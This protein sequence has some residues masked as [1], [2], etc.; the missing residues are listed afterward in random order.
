QEAAFSAV[1]LRPGGGGR[2]RS[3][4][5]HPCKEGCQGCSV[6][7]EQCPTCREDFRRSG[8][9]VPQKGPGQ[10]RDGIRALTWSPA[11]YLD[12]LDRIQARVQRMVHLRNQ[13]QQQRFK[14]LQQR[15]NVVGLCVMYKV[16][17]QQTPHLAPLRL[18]PPPIATHDTRHSHH[19]PKCPTP[20]SSCARLRVTSAP[21]SHGKAAC[22]TGW[23]SPHAYTTTHA[24]R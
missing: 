19:R 20:H 8:D 10:I 24:S 6:E 15:R 1:H 2:R 17:R 9:S 18:P 16:L 5:Y 23:C 22:G 7:A 11:F 12:R 13:D 3:N 14:P 4:L 21:S